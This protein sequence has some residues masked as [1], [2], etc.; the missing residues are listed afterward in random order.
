MRRTRHRRRAFGVPAVP[1]RTLLASRAESNFLG[2]RKNFPPLTLTPASR[3]GLPAAS[4]AQEDLPVPQR[5]AV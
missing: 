1:L 5:A 3:G 2:I 4:S